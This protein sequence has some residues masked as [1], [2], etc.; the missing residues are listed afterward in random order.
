[1]PKAHVDKLAA[2]VSEIVRT[3][4]MRQKLAMQGWQAVGSSP[5]GLS[6]RIQQD[7]EALG[8]LLREQHI[9]AQ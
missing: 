8:T 6:Y 2:A 9:T 7:V 4:E 1:M 5:V 3:P